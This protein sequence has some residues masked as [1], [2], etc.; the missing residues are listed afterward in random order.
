MWCGVVGDN[1]RQSACGFA[2]SV[3]QVQVV[4]R[5]I[6]RQHCGAISPRPDNISM[7]SRLPHTDWCRCSLRC[8]HEDIAQFATT[9]S[10][11]LTELVIQR[12]LMLKLVPSVVWGAWWKCAHCVGCA[13]W[14]STHRDGTPS[15]FAGT[16]SLHSCRQQCLWRGECR[17]RVQGKLC[18]IRHRGTLDVMA[19]LGSK[20]FAF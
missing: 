15:R 14:R 11:H 4:H 17:V 13:P 18:Q 1:A 5:T 19:R 20:C 8:E 6:V 12:K 10:S 2:P 3:V 7:A 16:H 9:K